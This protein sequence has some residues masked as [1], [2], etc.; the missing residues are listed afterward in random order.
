MKIK[1]IYF[2]LF[3]AVTEDEGKEKLNQKPK[4]NI[5]KSENKSKDKK[6]KRKRR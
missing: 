1:K 2:F 3:H 4:F 6:K 5:K